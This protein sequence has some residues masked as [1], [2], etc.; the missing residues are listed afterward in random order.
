MSENL[1]K[2]R[3]TITPL[4]RL[5]RSILWYPYRPNGTAI[6]LNHF[7]FGFVTCTSPGFQYLLIQ[8]FMYYI[9]STLLNLKYEYRKLCFCLQT[10]TIIKSL[11]G[12]A[13][14]G[15]F[16]CF[17]SFTLYLFNSFKRKHL[18][19][20]KSAR[21][22]KALSNSQSFSNRQRFIYSFKLHYNKKNHKQEN[23][24]TFLKL[25]LTHNGSF[26]M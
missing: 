21:R 18:E 6:I 1:P 22:Q 10:L 11:S 12:S 19:Q 7:L 3:T 26:V 2:L 24:L 9:L 5:F 16:L 15:V 25:Q 23:V 14:G 4:F 13:V 20:W 17:V 8:M